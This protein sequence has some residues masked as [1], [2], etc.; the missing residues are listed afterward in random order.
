MRTIKITRGLYK[1]NF[2]DKIYTLKDMKKDCGYWIICNIDDSIGA[3]KTK[4]EC[5]NWIATHRG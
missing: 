4:K 3:E 2:N 5:L 1:V